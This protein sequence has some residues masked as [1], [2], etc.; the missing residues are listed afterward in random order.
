MV[1]IFGYIGWLG[2]WFGQISMRLG[3]IFYKGLTTPWSGGRVDYEV[4]GPAKIFKKSVRAE[5]PKIAPEGPR[6]FP[7]PSKKYNK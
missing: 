1:L 2:K 6:V 5:N 3:E 4:K 7:N